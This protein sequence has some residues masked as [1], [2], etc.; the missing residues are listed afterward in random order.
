MKLAFGINSGSGKDT[1]VDYLICKYGGKK[2]SFA[3][4][5]YDILFYSQRTLDLPLQKDRKFLQQFGDFFKNETTED[6]FVDL[7][8]KKIRSLP[9]SENIYISDLRFENEFKKLKNEGFKCVKIIRDTDNSGRIANGLKEHN[10]ETSLKNI[11]DNE[12][13]HI[14]YNNSS[15]DE[16]Y[17]Q[18]D[19]IVS[20][21]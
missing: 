16:L 7:C 13:D 15:L 6:I 5:L 3:S 1:S 2:Y 10:S 17:T 20:K 9:P 11:D 4:P 14:I 12:W 18:L 8:L 21:Y 19:N